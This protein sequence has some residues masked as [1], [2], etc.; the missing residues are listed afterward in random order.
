M[1]QVKTMMGTR[2]L[3]PLLLEAGELLD[4]L[5]KTCEVGTMPERLLRKIPDDA[6]IVAMDMD[7]FC[8]KVRILLESESLPEGYAFPGYLSF[9]P[10]LY[11]REFCFRADTATVIPL[12]KLQ[13]VSQQG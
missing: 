9:H 11:P 2:R 3:M 12:D 1:E 10:L 4:F 8:G 13:P 5:R 7:M 6:K